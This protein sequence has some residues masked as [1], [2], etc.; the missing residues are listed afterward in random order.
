MGEIKHSLKDL[1]DIKEMFTAITMKYDHMAVHF[2]GN[3]LKN[4]VRFLKINQLEIAGSSHSTPVF[5]TRYAK[6]DFPKFLVMIHLGGFIN[7]KDSLNIIPL[8]IVIR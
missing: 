1:G 6:I 5:G 7:A 3:T 8:I 2:L 4:H